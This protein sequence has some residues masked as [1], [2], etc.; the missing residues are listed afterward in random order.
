MSVLA[1]C[2]VQHSVVRPCIASIGKGAA[3]AVLRQCISAFLSPL[4]Q[5]EHIQCVCVFT[6]LLSVRL[7][8]FDV[9][10]HVCRRWRSHT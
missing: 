2:A 9:K 10:P 4:L 3:S 1:A 6:R 7:H 8:D 5:G